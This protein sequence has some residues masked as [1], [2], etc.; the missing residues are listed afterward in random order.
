M[1]LVV[2]PSAPARW[3]CVRRAV[4]P[5]RQE[6]PAGACTRGASASAAR[7]PAQTVNELPQPQPPLAFGLLKVNPEPWKVET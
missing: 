5:W 7:R 2:W 6:S 3:F 1:A 4:S